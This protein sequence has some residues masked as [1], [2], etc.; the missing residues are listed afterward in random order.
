MPLTVYHLLH[1]TYHFDYALV[2]KLNLYFLTLK[3]SHEE[4]EKRK[5][6]LDIESL[7]SAG[8]K[9]IKNRCVAKMSFLKYN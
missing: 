5:K 9:N 3:N 6:R 7:S 2:C 4:E 1:A 8:I